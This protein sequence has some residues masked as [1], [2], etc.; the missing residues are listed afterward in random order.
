[1]TLP[2]RPAGLQRK[3]KIQDAIFL[4]IKEHSCP[5]YNV[6]EEVKVAGGAIS[7]SSYKAVCFTLAGKVLE[8]VSETSSISGI[9]PVRSKK[10]MYDCGGCGEGKLFLEYKQEKEFATLQMKM[11]S[12]AEEMRRKQY[13]ERYFGMLRKMTVFEPLEDDALRDLT[14]LLEF[15]TIPVDKVVVKKGEPGNHLNIILAG[16][17]GVLGD[18]GA[19]IAEMGAGEIF[20]EMSML[21]GDPVANTIHSLEVVQL[22]RLSLKNF[23][24]VVLKH[25]VLQLFLFKLLVERAQTAAIRE[26]NIASGMTGKLEEIAVVDLLQLINSAQKT[27]TVVLSLPGGQAQVVFV[28]GQVVFARYLELRDREALFALLGAARGFF[29]YTKGIPKTLSGQPP[30]GDFMAMLMEGMQRLDEMGG[31]D[32]GE[33]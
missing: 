29:S 17:T 23:K 28:D 6:G 27:G 13:L 12:E 5:I 10:R 31:G 24:Y 11:L 26:G 15:R 25:P 14:L 8:I 33:E 9:T 2:S 7:V 16:R 18:D 3:P 4:V 22:A 1:M 19:L 21:T 20:G 32:M 30:I